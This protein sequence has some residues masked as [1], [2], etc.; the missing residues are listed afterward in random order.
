MGQWLGDY[1]EQK[2]YNKTCLRVRFSHF[3][4]TFTTLRHWPLR[5]FKN[6]VSYSNS[7]DLMQASAYFG[8]Q[9]K[10]KLFVGI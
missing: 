5:I 6:L 4:L 1:D 2:D 3:L 7:F 10:L 8:Q 9:Q